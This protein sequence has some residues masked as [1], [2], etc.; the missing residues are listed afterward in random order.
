MKTRLLNSIDDVVLHYARDSG[1]TIQC[2]LTQRPEAERQLFEKKLLQS[3]APEDFASLISQYEFERFFIGGFSVWT[4]SRKALL[5]D[6][7]ENR[8][9]V[10]P[11]H[12][13]N[14]GRYSSEMI[15]FRKR[16]KTYNVTDSYTEELMGPLCTDFADL[17]VHLANLDI[18]RA[19][20]GEDFFPDI[21]AYIEKYCAQEGTFSQDAWEYLLYI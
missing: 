5:E 10:E 19:R 18:I 20:S 3:G 2:R 16:D 11:A 7:M 14:C 17:I 9:Y 4:N 21:Q 15:L 1:R 6:L 8:Q 12:F 13:Y